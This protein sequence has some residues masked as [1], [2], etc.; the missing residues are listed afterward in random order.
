MLQPGLMMDFPLTIPAILRRAAQ[1]FPEKQIISRLG[2]GSLHR[3]TYG[4]LNRRVLR[5]MNVLRDLGVKS[6]DRV[7][8]FAWNSY[9]HLELYFAVP[10]LGAILHPLNIR[11]FPEQL[12]YILQHAKDRAVFA[13]R[14]L[15]GF[16]AEH[17]SALK[18]VEHYVL[19]DDC[20]SSS[21]ALP[22]AALDYETLLA[23]AREEAC[24]PVYDENSA[25]S[26]C[27]TSGTTGDP[28]GVLYS[29]RSVYLHA[30]GCCMADSFGIREQEVVLPVVP[31]YHANAWGL[32]YAC[33]M[34]GATQVLPGSQ[35]FGK[36]L[37][38]LMER[39]RVTFAAG[40]PTIWNLFYQHL[41]QH[42]Y[43]LSHLKVILSGGSAISQSLIANYEREFGIQVLN[44]WGMTETSPVG[45]LC[46]LKAQMEDWP[47]EDRLRVRIKQGL[48]VAN[49]EMRIRNEA[50]E[51]LL[52][53]GKEAGEL[54]VRGPW[55]A[56]AYYGSS[57]ADC[58]FTEDGWFQTG[59]IATLDADGYME[60]T[61]RKKDVIKSRGEWISSVEME[62]V[63][64]SHTAILEAAVVGRS[65][66][67]RGEAPVLYAVLRDPQQHVAPQEL[68]EALKSHFAQWQLPRLSDIHFVDSLP[69]TS[70]GKMDKK[71]LRSGSKE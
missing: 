19:M 7:A 4:D 15:A 44:A 37:A 43:D 31:M 41:Q 12:L 2:D 36:P 40:V 5:L 60:I 59:D 66:A 6:G 30:M 71:A 65:D 22:T 34:T 69:K 14:S 35:L 64:L 1:V 10:A 63:V 23:G 9:R 13:D 55:V 45:S 58:A 39:E 3:Y 46:R 29:H 27:Y 51:E 25:A 26:L 61:D 21:V 42:S 38:E 8:T 32:P 11:L 18:T 48:P 57:A 28:K 33:A 49:L 47:S 68:L 54:E 17:Q 62:N 50:G 52:R 70:V 67:L 16:F 53:D 24:F 56:R 20:V